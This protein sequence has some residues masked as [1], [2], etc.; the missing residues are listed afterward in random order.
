MYK[1][2]TKYCKP[3][4]KAET[5]ILKEV[6]MVVVVV[7]QPLFLA[8]QIQVLTFQYVQ[9]VELVLHAQAMKAYLQIL[10]TAQVVVVVAGLSRVR[11]KAGLSRVRVKA[12]LSH[13]IVTE[14]GLIRAV[15]TSI[16]MTPKYALT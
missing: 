15:V 12:G 5:K 13:V 10:Q 6:V 2:R 9:A 4:K 16:I 14:A 1:T 7:L 3:R 8:E 11:V